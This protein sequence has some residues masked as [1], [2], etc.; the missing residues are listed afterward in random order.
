MEKGRKN[1]W[2]MLQLEEH[3]L[4]TSTNT[5]IFKFCYQFPRYNSH[6]SR[7]IKYHHK[8]DLVHKITTLLN[9]SSFP[10][11]NIGVRVRDTSSHDPH[12]QWTNSFNFQFHIIS[13]YNVRKH[14]LQLA[15]S[16]ISSRA[17][18]SSVAKR[19][20]VRIR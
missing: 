8:E 14:E 5:S 10:E 19:K 3:Y 6:I 16:K 4:F 11:E 2:R 17:N 18:V 12:I 15:S 9:V 20:V 7:T 13:H 1:E